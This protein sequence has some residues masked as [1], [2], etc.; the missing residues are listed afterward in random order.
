MCSS[1]LMVSASH[2]VNATLYSKLPF[3]P[4]KDFAGVTL[5]ASV[6]N[7]LVVNTSVP[8]T[9]V[10]EL[11][12]LAKARPG[13]L[14]CG[15]AGVGAAS[16]LNLELFKS[17][18]SVDIVHVPFK[19]FSEQLTELLAGRLQMTWAP[20]VLALSHIQGGRLRALGVSTLKR[21]SSLPDVPTVA[22]AALPGFVFD[23][24]FAVLVP[25]GTPRRIIDRLNADIVRTLQMP[26]VRERLLAQGAEPAWNKPAELDAYVRA[27][28]AKLGRKI[29]RAHV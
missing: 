19:G 3:D 11:I 14:N 18:A 23:P 25:A 17:T 27:E 1:D 15:S 10:K 6:P 21:S 20:Q 7:V 13:A 22:E 4:A 2:A 8:A 16:H 9:S 26:D 5:V 28:I 12:A 24:W 29:G